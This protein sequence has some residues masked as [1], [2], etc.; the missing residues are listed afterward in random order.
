MKDD[1]VHEDQHT[2]NVKNQ[3]SSKANKTP[4]TFEDASYTE[5]KDEPKKVEPAKPEKE[6]AI[7]PS[8][9][10]TKE[11]APTGNGGAQKDLK[12]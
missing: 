11:P 12:F 1:E 5:V 6:P 3:I 2:A 8:E 4:V 10:F 7:K 9:E